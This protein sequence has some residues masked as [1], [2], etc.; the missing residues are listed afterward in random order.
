MRA[1]EFGN[2]ELT[3]RGICREMRSISV[4]YKPFPHHLGKFMLCEHIAHHTLLS[5]LPQDVTGVVFFR[6]SARARESAMMFCNF[7]VLLHVELY[8]I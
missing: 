5:H 4:S 1:I 7:Y 3:S 8:W 6:G 2:E